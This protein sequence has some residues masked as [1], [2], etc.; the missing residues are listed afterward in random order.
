MYS[1]ETGEERID[2]QEEIEVPRELAMNVAIAVVEVLPP[3]PSPV[4]ELSP[5]LSPSPPLS[6]IE[7]QT[8]SS[9][10]TL[11]HT[12]PAHSNGPLFFLLAGPRYGLSLAESTTF[13]ALRATK[14]AILLPFSLAHRLPIIGSRIP[15]PFSP[16][17]STSTPSPS[18]DSFKSPGFGETHEEKRQGIVW[19]VVELSLGVGLVSLWAAG[20]G[21][22]ML[23]NTVGGKTGEKETLKA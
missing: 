5:S 23:W 15:S 19:D 21:V 13:L 17:P 2:E 20:V 1:T 11:V 6:S 16:P 9:E 10:N 12:P 3:S 14:S 4:P 22:L 8:T 7:T 18:P